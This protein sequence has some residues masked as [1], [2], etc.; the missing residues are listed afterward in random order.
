M[1]HA[2][3]AVRHQ[4]LPR[5]R[6]HFRIRS[7]GAKLVSA[8]LVAG[9]AFLSGCGAGPVTASSSANAAFSISPGAALIDTNCSGCNSLNNHAS[10]VHQFSATLNSGGSAPVTWS[11]SGGDPASGPGRITADGQYT[12]PNYLSG[13]R[14]QIMV[15]A[16]LKSDP[17]IRATSLLTL[18]PGFLQP[19]TPEN[20]A[21]AAGGS[22]TVTGYLAEAGG[23]GEIHFA[24]S[25]SPSGDSGGEG[26]LSATSCQRTRRAF[27]TC[28]VTYTAPTAVSFTGVTYVV[29]TLPG[30]NRKNRNCRS[31]Q[32]RWRFQQSRHSSRFSVSA[33]VARQFRRQQQ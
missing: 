14:A 31:S 4:L 18:T 9:T 2:I 22:I 1:P 33:Y 26:A 3:Q 8:L 12:P 11:V 29:A 28:S 15:T 21:I 32:C 7:R 13:D 27:T 10:P 20:A 17:S 30:S 19:L 24:L 16:A 25:N 5:A 6:E 23:A